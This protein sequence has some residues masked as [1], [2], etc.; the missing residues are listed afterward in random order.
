M[1]YK[2]AIDHGLEDGGKPGIREDY[3]KDYYAAYIYDYDNN[4][5]EVLTK[6]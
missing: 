5:I 2:I 1:F 4:K 3:A 6:I